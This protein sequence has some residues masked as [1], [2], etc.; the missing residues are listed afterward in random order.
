MLSPVSVTSLLRITT[1]L[2]GKVGLTG[3]F[4]FLRLGLLPALASRGH[5]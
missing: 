1:V 2:L 4:L 3:Y 5:W